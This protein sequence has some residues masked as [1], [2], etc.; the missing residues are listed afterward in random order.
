[1][2]ISLAG[3]LGAI[4]GTV[5]AAVT[6]GP[7]VNVV[8]RAF[9]SRGAPQTATERATFENELLVLRRAVLAVDILVF[10]GLGYWLGMLIEK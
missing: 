1:M 10:A 6:Y 7:V 3:L 8:E 5:V 9:R 4:I 2:E